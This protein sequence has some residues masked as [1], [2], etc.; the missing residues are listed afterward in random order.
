LEAEAKVLERDRDISVAKVASLEVAIQDASMATARSQRDL[1]N[2]QQELDQASSK[3]KL[4]LLR[5][6]IWK[7]EADSLRSLVQTYDDNEPDT[8]ACGRS[9]ATMTVD[10]A[11]ATARDEAA[12]IRQEHD[13]LMKALE[14]ATI[15]KQRLEKEHE[16]VLDKYTKLRDALLAE[17]AKTEDAEDRAMKA[18]TLLL[19]RAC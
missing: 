9:A 6:K 12:V 2:S 10:L 14:T 16:R 4:C 3:F 11:L 17:R 19:E 15:E 13:Q 1:K 7:R 5:E 8:P 18:E